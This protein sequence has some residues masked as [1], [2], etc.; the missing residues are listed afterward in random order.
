MIINKARKIEKMRLSGDMYKI[1]PAKSG[2]FYKKK[3][4][5]SGDNH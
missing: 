1:I 4:A 3:H 2:T 5:K